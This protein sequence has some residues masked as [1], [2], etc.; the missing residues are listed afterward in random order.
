MQALRG[1]KIVYQLPHQM[2]QYLLDPS[3]KKATEGH[4]QFTSH[5]KIA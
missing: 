3:E 4:R 5:I 1:K 2:K